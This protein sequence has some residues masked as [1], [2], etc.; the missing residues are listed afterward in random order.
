MA[1]IKNSR[2]AIRSHSASPETADGAREEATIG[3]CHTNQQETTMRPLFSP[4]KIGPYQLAHRVVM[5]PL[6]RMRS[7]LGDIPSNLMVEYYS[8]RASK[9]GLIISEATPSLLPDVVA[10]AISNGRIVSVNPK[11]KDIPLV[12]AT[13]GEDAGIAG[14]AALSYLL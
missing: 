13:Y 10:Q 12:P 9:G 2:S 6:T 14:G 8:Q 3:R 7:D 11:A 5:A 1:A 4:I